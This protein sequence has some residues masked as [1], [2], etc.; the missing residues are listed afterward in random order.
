MEDKDKG[1]RL[2]AF[3]RE[4]CP[5]CPPVKEFLEVHAKDVEWIDCDTHEGLD[6]AVRFGVQSTPTVIRLGE[7][8]KEIGRA[9][10]VGEVKKLL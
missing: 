4:R 8:G 2:L 6:M 5:S 1:G 3:V 10:A 9:H 7:D